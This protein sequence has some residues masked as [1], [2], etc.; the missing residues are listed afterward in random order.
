M[1]SPLLSL[2]LVLCF[3]SPVFGQEKGPLTPAQTIPLEN[4]E[5][6]ID[7]MAVDVAGQ[8]L[9]VAALGNNTVEVVGLNA[10][11]KI[12]SLTGF[13]EPQGLAWLPGFDKLV[14]A[15]GGDGTCRFLDGGSFKT[16]S[17]VELGDDADNVRYD[18]KAKQIYVGYGSGALAVLDARTSAKL[19][20][21][22][23]PGHPE[24]FRLETAGK[25]I[26]INIPDSLQISVADREERVVKESW[27]L[28]EV[29][30]NFPMCLDEANHR[31]FAGCRSPARILVCDTSSSI[32]LITS[33]P[34][35]DDTDDLFFDTANKVLYVSC[36]GG[37]IKV[38]KQ[39]DADTYK[40]VQTI[41]T[42]P[43]ARTSLF[44]PE[45]KIFCLAV[46]HRGSQPAEIRVFK[47]Q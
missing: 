37:S 36:G 13:T 1:K 25:R 42:A 11:K 7:H 41:P 10:G 20:S 6:R 38:I 23:L 12:R 33:I 44:I 18:E 32:R 17:T 4:V 15:N 2:T 21:I 16:V 43:G 22:K 3:L 46:P 27:P 8:R 28:K 47:T 35:P 5:G 30:S 24:S 26:F 9:F 14:V 34:I 40:E 31:L 19:A 45:L 39:L 29:K